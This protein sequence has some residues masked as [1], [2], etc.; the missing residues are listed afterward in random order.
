MTAKLSLKEQLDYLR[1]MTIRLGVL[2]EAQVLQI[3][4]WPLLI[5]GVKK[6]KSYINI[7]EKTVTYDCVFEKTVKKVNKNSKVYKMMEMVTL[8]VQTILWPETVVIFNCN[9]QKLYD[10]RDKNVTK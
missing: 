3:K 6:A 9:K 5:P 4:N 7:E 2:H 10:S 1:G 8:W